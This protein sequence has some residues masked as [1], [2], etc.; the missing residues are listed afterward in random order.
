MSPGALS[1]DLSIEPRPRMVSVVRRFVE[2]T[3]D[4]LIGDPDAVFRIGMTA[5]ELLE[6]AAKY[7][8]GERAQLQVQLLDDGTDARAVL[9][10]SNETTVVHIDRLRERVA[11]VVGSDDPFTLYTNL[12]RRNVR[13][14]ADSGLGL[15]RIRAEGE[16][17]LGLEVRGTT[18]T[19]LASAR[20][21]RRQT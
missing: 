8:V 15:A 6:N 2:E 11:E 16:M 7:A 13:D 18:V 12:M 10:L 5:H 17:S 3:L 20:I 14:T 9:A 19:I 21:P 4:R 1:F